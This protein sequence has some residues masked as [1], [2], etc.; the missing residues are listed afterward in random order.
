MMTY[1]SFTM[2]IILAVFI[3]AILSAALAGQANEK[4]ATGIAVKLGFEPFPRENTCE[5][6]DLSPR[7]EI[8]G[9][10]AT[11]L[12]MILEDPDAP[13]GTFIHWI[14]WNIPPNH[15]IPSAIAKKAT[16]SDPFQCRQGY[17][18]FGEIGYAGPCPPSGKPHRYFFRVFCLDCMLDLP[19]GSSAGEL[20]EAMQGH[21]VQ[22]GQAMA[23]FGR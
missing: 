16:L 11:S 6:A 4:E 5:G 10:N 9:C 7:I 1:S 20:R 17:N 22:Q 19:A 12:A 15:I 18:D 21:I 2:R 8:Q 13:S 3:C 14:I 23:R